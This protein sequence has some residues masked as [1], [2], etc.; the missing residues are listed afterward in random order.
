MTRGPDPAQSGTG[1]QWIKAVDFG[2]PGDRPVAGDWV[3][4]HVGFAMSKIDESEAHE[5]MR[6]LR[7]MG[8][9]FVRE[10][11]G[12]PARK[13]RRAGESERPGRFGGR[14]SRKSR[15]GCR[16]PPPG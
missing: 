12:G 3:L 7:T 9:V 10:T 6:S 14:S 11:A 8:D 16:K 13:V 2:L 5:T 4:I 1:S 15:R